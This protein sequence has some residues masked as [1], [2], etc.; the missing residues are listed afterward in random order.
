MKNFFFVVFYLFLATGYS[1]IINLDKNQGNFGRTLTEQEL[2][3]VPSNEIDVKLSGKTKYTDYKIISF[4]NDTTVID[5]TLSLKK[6]YKF[7]FLQKDDFELLPLHNQGQTLS[8]LSY[9]FKKISNT[10]NFGFKE[11]Q[12]NFYAIKDV[13]YYQVPT[14]TSEIMYRTGLEQGQVLNAL[15]TANFSK[16]MNIAMEYKGLRS[17]GHYRRTLSSG[18][19]FRFSFLYETPNEK[20]GV[21]GHY[22]NQGAFNQESGGLTKTALNAFI[23]N[24]KNFKGNRGRMDVNLNDA[25]NTFDSERFFVEQTLKL[26]SSKDSLNQ[27]NFSNLKLGHSI[28]RQFKS[29]K[30]EQNKADEKFFSKAIT[31]K[32]K[33]SVYYKLLSNQLFL[34]FSSKYVLGKFRVKTTYSKYK[35]GYD[36]LI[37][38]A[39]K[40]IT[41]RKLRGNAISFGADWKARIKK[42]HLNAFAEI[43]P[44]AGRLAGSNFYGEAFYKKDSLITIKSRLAISSKTPNF[45][46]LML[47]S[48]YNKYNWQN[49]FKNI[50]IQNLGGSIKSKWGNASIDISNI[51]NFTYFNKNS[52]PKQYKDNINYL[53][54]KLEK[55]FTF[56]KFA[57]DNTLLYQK[58]AKGQEVLR[59]P[60]LITRNTIYYTDNWFKGKPLL[61]NIGLTLKYFTKYKA[62]DYNPLLA[63]FYLQNHTKIGNYPIV[64]FFVNGRV[65]RTRIYFT[66]ENITSSF[67]GRSYFSAP[68]YPYKDF[69]FRFGL[70]WN[71]FI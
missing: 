45:N 13:N 30:F 36:Y 38:S 6:H 61:I 69:S 24:D 18:G 28:T 70:V 65:R 1:Q 17:L 51:N 68:G 53:K 34:D 35:Y 58:V 26:F 7:N 8:K 50:N 55:E 66:F 42:F 22:T 2:D 71:W 10:P 19:N 64:D 21:R 15:F 3:S 47:Q 48:S 20:Y 27:R 62:N 40:K 39:S 41:K 43:T 59:V 23:T 60:E 57:L 16:K 31:S 46:T 14:P 63:E 33:D 67:T 49:N 37:N 5:T 44:G 32:I 9:N 54:V 4:E 11:K 56:G 25:E 12:F 52:T 29:Y